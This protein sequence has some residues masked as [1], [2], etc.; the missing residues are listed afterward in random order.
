MHRRWLRLVLHPVQF[1]AGPE[2]TFFG[3]VQAYNWKY[4]GDARIVDNMV[5]VMWA[6]IYLTYIK[7]P[8]QCEMANVALRFLRDYIQLGI[9]VLDI[10]IKKS[11]GKVQLPSSVG[12]LVLV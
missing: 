4:G 7:C 9:F 2:A 5:C 8:V 1:G 12:F 6:K 10:T 3:E 11:F